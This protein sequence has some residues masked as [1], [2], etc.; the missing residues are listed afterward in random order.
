MKAEVISEFVC[1]YAGSGNI[2]TRIVPL[3]GGLDSCGTARVELCQDGST[4]RQIQ[5]GL[6][7]A[8]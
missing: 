2:E 7:L 4:S 6:R 1:E 3:R 8:F 5:F